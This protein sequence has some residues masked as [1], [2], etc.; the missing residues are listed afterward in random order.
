MVNVR[1]R[2]GS[3]GQV[4]DDRKVEWS[5][6][7]VWRMLVWEWCLYRKGIGANA[8]APNIDM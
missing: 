6:E 7:G 4:G 2:G 3:S 1:R 8:I 5:K